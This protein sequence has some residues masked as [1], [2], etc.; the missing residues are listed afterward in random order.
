[1]F[2]NIAGL[3]EEWVFKGMYDLQHGYDNLHRRK[4]RGDDFQT[5][6]KIV[7]SQTALNIPEIDIC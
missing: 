5:V 3:N 1:L 2:W 7:S 6:S 4:M